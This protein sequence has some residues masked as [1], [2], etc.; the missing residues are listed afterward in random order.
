[1]DSLQENLTYSKKAKDVRN[2]GSDIGDPSTKIQ[3]HIVTFIALFGNPV[4]T[5]HYVLRKW[6]FLTLRL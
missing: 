6:N 5:L 3:K 2:P 4:S 1:M